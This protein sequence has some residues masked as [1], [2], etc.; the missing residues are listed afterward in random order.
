VAETKLLERDNGRAEDEGVSARS[1]GMEDW[2]SPL[3]LIIIV[4][5]Y[6][7][8]TFTWPSTSGRPPPPPERKLIA[9]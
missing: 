6:C 3:Y 2:I 7:D 4:L 1:E 9:V 8:F 5:C